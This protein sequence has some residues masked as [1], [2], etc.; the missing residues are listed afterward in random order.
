VIIRA[1]ITEMI[2]REDW[3]GCLFISMQVQMTCRGAF[4]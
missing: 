2:K 4:E 1:I 3:S